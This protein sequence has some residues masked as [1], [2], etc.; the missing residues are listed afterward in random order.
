V[1]LMGGGILSILPF[2]GIWMLPLGLLLLAEDLPPVRR[3]RDRV[4]DWIAH[5]RPHWFAEARS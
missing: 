3:V 2:L 5:H 1:L 4:L